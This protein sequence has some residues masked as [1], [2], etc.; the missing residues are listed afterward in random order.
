PPVGPPPDVQHLHGRAR[1]LRRARRLP[2]RVSELANGRGPDAV[3]LDVAGQ[4]EGEVPARLASTL[5]P[6][7]ARGQSLELRAQPRRAACRLVSGVSDG[8]GGNRTR[9]RFPNE[10][11][12]VTRSLTRS[13]RFGPSTTAVSFGE[14][15]GAVSPRILKIAPQ[16]IQGLG[17]PAAAPSV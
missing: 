9:A 8:G 2:G 4:R 11:A 7:A 3:P 10:A 5:R 6:Q 14:V 17:V 1:G 15:A 13:N 12:S 16:R